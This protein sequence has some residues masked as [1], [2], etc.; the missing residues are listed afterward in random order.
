MAH[1]LRDGSSVEDIRLDRLVQFDERSREFPVAAVLPEEIK[2]GRTWSVPAYLDQGSE[3]ACVGFGISHELA[4]YPAAVPG[5]NYSFAFNLYKSA[6]R[7]DP[8]PGENYSGTSVLAGVKVAQSMGYFDSYR[9]AFSVEDILRALSHEGPVVVGT[10]WN[11]SMY[12]PRPDGLLEVGNDKIVGG[13]CYLIRGFQMK[14]RLK[15]VNEPVLRI[16][17]SWGKDWGV[18]GDAFIRLSDYE[19]YLLPD[20][21]AVI[22]MGR[23]KTVSRPVAVTRRESIWD[24]SFRLARG[25]H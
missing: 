16:R 3:G 14:P 23:H 2:H 4:A 11:E 6:Q 20:G 25:W 9:W 12:S 22:F 18:K 15:G 17:N 5:L 24:R 19:K 10:M 7:I 8:W 13:H 21:E 1:S